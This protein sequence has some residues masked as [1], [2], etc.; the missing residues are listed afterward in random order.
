MSLGRSFSVALLGVDGAVIECEADLADGLPGFTLVGLPDAS[1]SESKDRVRAAVANSGW[2]WPSRKITVGLLPATLPK[3]GSSFDLAMALAVL[4]GA[5]QVPAPALDEHVVLGELGLDGRVRAVRGV[6]PMVLAAARAGRTR[7]LVPIDNAHEARLVPG[8]EIVGVRS[9]RDAVAYLA[10]GVIPPQPR[11]D[12]PSR[13]Q[14]ASLDLAQVGGQAKARRAIE[15]AA[16][17]GHHIFLL[18]APGAGKTM[19]AERLPG[20]L[21]LLSDAWALEVSAI[22]SL[23]GLLDEGAPLVR[24]PPF[25]APHHSATI[26]ALV[27]GGGAVLR[28]GDISCAHRGVLFLDEAPEFRAGA[29]DAMRQPLES[30]IARISRARASV[31]F[32]CRSTVV[33]A[34]NPCPC[35]RTSASMGCECTSTVRRRYLG[36]LS[37]PL[38]DR[39]DIRVWIEPVS[40]ADL[41]SDQSAIEPSAVVAA[42]VAQARAA[43]AER[44]QRTPWQS[45]GE[46]PA[47][48]LRTRWP[49]AESVLG[50]VAR[51]L[52]RG[53]LS[54]RGFDRVIRLGWTLADLAGAASPGPV[55]LGEAL[56]L[57][58]EARLS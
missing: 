1:L 44:L 7:M 27:G 51:C 36:K 14:L 55:E 25:R 58:T 57:R 20:L 13:A 32:P 33:M 6:L 50:S 23:A 12:E 56:S 16:A 34:A 19:L 8:V 17:G 2:V 26:P 10:E 21:P 9:L 24:V 31:E 53:Q 29:L 48:E 43:A 41:I 15:V 54:M 38:L 5:S 3:T 22:H 46:V 37:G 11:Q 52:D 47:H 4:S 49:L 42:R 28:P 30:G 39:V 45:M 40:R 35:A 18:G